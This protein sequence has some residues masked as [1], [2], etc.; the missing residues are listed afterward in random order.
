M[1]DT[2]EGRGERRESKGLDFWEGGLDLANGSFGSVFSSIRVYSNRFEPIRFG[3]NS[4]VLLL[5]YFF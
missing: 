4:G 2:V 3:S 5:F 1:I